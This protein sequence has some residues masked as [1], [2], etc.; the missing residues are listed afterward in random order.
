MSRWVCRVISTR[1]R[2]AELPTDVDAS[3]APGFALAEELTP[4]AGIKH[5]H[6]HHQLLYASRGTLALEVATAT[7]Q[8]PP[9]RA[10]VIASGVQHRVAVTAPASLRTLYLPSTWNLGVPECAVFDAP[11]LCRELILHAMRWGPEREPTDHAPNRFFRVLG[12]LCRAWAQSPLALRLPAPQS[13]AAAVAMQHTRACL[14]TATI[15]S[16]ASAAAVSPRTLARRFRH[17]TGETWRAYQK[18][19]RV[20]SAMERLSR[21]DWSVLEVAN[22]VG[23]ESQSAF[24]AAFRSVLGITPRAY[25]GTMKGA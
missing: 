8:L 7:W 21:P 2:V 15:E 9:Q 16:A 20:V 24:T 4:G 22:A 10:A 11:P 3:L 19:A 25:R 6:M 1:E 12:D 13:Q 17:E 18:T 23:Y 5:V 14:A